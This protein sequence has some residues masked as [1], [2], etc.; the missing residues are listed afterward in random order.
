MVQ[1]VHE[2]LMNRSLPESFRFI[3]L[4]LLGLIGDG[5]VI[6]EFSGGMKW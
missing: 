2:T 6:Y 1:I 3:I 4:S 5:F